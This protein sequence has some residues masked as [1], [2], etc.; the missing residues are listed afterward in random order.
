MRAILVSLLMTGLLL[1]NTACIGRMALSGKVGK[2]NLEVVDGKW[3][4]E[5][6]FLA[7]YIIPV[8]PIAGAIDLIIVNSIEFWV[9]EN[10]ISG[11]PRLALAG[12]QKYVIAADGSTATSTLL[13]DG[14]IDVEIQ[15]TD[16][17]SHFLNLVREDGHA[18]ARDASGQRVAM[19]DPITGEVVSLTE[20][21]EL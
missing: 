10:P 15:A 13:E 2:F 19:I 12:E 20:T 9:G 18:V 17:S 6:V 4:R 16:G 7:L 3:P 1:S 8:Y 21:S 5:F 14:S 11:Q